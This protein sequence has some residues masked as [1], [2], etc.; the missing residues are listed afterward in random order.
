MKKNKLRFLVYIIISIFL[1]PTVVL[2]V[3]EGNSLIG[4]DLTSPGAKLTIDIKVASN[5]TFKKYEADLTYETNVLELVGIENKNN[6]TGTN[7]LTSKSPLALKFEHDGGVS[8]ESTLATLTFKVKSDAT[9]AETRISLVGKVTEGGTETDPGTIKNLEESSKTIQIKSTDNT[10]KDLKINGETVINFSPSTY[11]YSMQVESNITSAKVEAT[12]NN[13]TASFVDKFGPRDVSLEYGENKIELKVKSASGEEKAYV[14]NITRN[15]NRG[16]NNNLKNVIINSGDVKI[17][18]DQN[19]LEYRIKTY[20]LDKIDVVCETVD[21][22]AKCEVKKPEKPEVGPN[23]IEIIVTSEDGKKKTYKIVL[24]NQDR[25]INVT[26]RDIKVIAKEENVVLTPTFKSDILDYEIP[27]KPSYNGNLVVIPEVSSKDDDVK[28]DE[29]LLESTLENLKV[30]SKVE[31][32]VYAPD[33]TENLYTITFVKDNRINFYTILFGV[34]LLILLV[35]F[36]KLIIDRK[37]INSS[38][39]INPVDDKVK[40]YK[41]ESEQE[42]MKTKRLNKINLE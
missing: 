2:A 38:V 15:D 26:L 28:Y 23:N 33:G 22:K 11:S 4:N 19:V 20:K 8:G 5:M 41:K 7:E 16:S 3:D 32:K 18:F 39:T 12:L 42:L 10:L 40:I 24:D 27:Y 34:I 13:N 37:K 6:W 1:I 21:P 36:I 17:N 35:I 14:V 29:A 9:K 30:G 25:E 31:I